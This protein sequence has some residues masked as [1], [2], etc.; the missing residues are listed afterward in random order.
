MSAS[1]KQGAS[2]AVRRFYD[3]LATDYHRIFRDWDVSMAHQAEVLDRL[4]TDRLGRGPHRLLDCACGIGTQAI[5]LARL[6]HTVVGSDLSPRAAARA[7]REAALRDTHLSA[8]AAD[9]R[10]LPFA[11]GTFDAVVCA[12]NALPHLLTPDDV[13]AALTAMRAMLVDSG[14]LVLTVR[15]YDELRRDRPATTPPQHRVTPDGGESVTVQ[16]WHWH[17]DGERYDLRHLQMIRE[18]SDWRVQERRTTYWALTR[19]QL[20]GFLTD[21]GFTEVTWQTPESTGFFQPVVTASAGSR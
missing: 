12:D 2:S 6:G 19:A 17:D 11:P 21:A 8:V 3:E 10:A 4:L 18:G 16:L 13:R 20:T 7:V 14:P 9:M 5:G 1:R 15:D